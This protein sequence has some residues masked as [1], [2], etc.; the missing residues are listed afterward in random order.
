MQT[1]SKLNF[2]STRDVLSENI[3][4]RDNA[5][6]F[7]NIALPLNSLTFIS[8]CKN[9]FIENHFCLSNS[10]AKCYDIFRVPLDDRNQ[11]LNFY[12]HSNLKKSVPK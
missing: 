3:V 9:N 11:Q 7:N 1:D 8:L 5:N 4:V 12:T 10:Y 2:T 6:N